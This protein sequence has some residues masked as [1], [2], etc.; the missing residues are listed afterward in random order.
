MLIME[1]Y[2]PVLT[3]AIGFGPRQ[4]FIG[5]MQAVQN[6]SHL[7]SSRCSD[8]TILTNVMS[9]TEDVYRSDYYNN[10]SQAFGIQHFDGHTDSPEDTVKF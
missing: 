10:Q 5:R 6:S 8:N 4:R 3:S 7:Q 1:L 9:S 2:A